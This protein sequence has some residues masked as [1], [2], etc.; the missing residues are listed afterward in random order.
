M[1][2]MQSMLMIFNAVQHNPPGHYSAV[3]LGTAGDKIRS[4]VYPTRPKRYTAC[5]ATRA[6][7]KRASPNLDVAA[8]PGVLVTSLPTGC[9]K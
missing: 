5:C 6:A 1:H 9:G 2:T 3:V 7:E 8:L 4:E